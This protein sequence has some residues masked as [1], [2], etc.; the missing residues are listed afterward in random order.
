MAAK[1]SIIAR[2]LSEYDAKGTKQA[3]K[4]LAELQKNFHDFGKKAAE[5][6]AVAA[7]AVVGLSIKLGI[8]GVKAAMAENQQM[9]VLANTLKNTTGAN[10]AAIA[11][12]SR[13]IQQSA[14]RYNFQ[15]NELIPSL[16][17]LAVA[18]G[19]IT[20]AE[21]LQGL[22]MNI[23]ANKG[24]DLASVS[25]VLAKAYLGNFTAL[26]KMGVPLSDAAIKSKNFAVVVK[27]LDK[28]FGG[29]AAAAADTFAG[30]VGRIGIAFDMVKKTIGQAIIV[31]LQPF[32]DKFMNALPQIEKWLNKNAAAIASFFVTGI[33]YGV[34]FAQVLY[35]TFKFVADNI[36]IFSELG[37]VLAAIWMGTKI[38]AGVNAIIAAVKTVVAVY[39][40]LRAAA[41][42]AAFAEAIA[43]GGVAAAVGLAAATAAFIGINLALNKF[44]K[45][46][47]KAGKGVGDL[48]FNFKGLGTTAADYLKGLKLTNTATDTSN[49]LTAL[50]IASLKALKALG[51]TPTTSTDPIELEAARLN[52]V[53]QGNIAEAEKI[54]LTLA[55]LDAQMQ[56][57]IAIQRYSDILG[58]LADQHISNEEI[59]VL[60]KKWKMSQDEVVAYIAKVTGAASFDPTEL[61]SPGAVAALGWKNALDALNKYFLALRNQ[62]AV[63]GGGGVVSASP[64]TD[65]AGTTYTGGTL[66]SSGAIAG[67][68]D[69]QG[70]PVFI[71]APGAP[72]ISGLGT[73]GSTPFPAASGTSGGAAPVVNVTVMGSVVTQADLVAGVANGLMQSQLSGTNYTVNML[74]L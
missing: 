14:L 35:D 50:Q 26:R 67:A 63:G 62:P 52:L 59:A 43:T 58:V 8:D 1:G 41:L 65:A 55:A 17:S 57:N 44:E 31:A 4:D 51:V 73:F 30:R 12:V 37:A 9:T 74:N 16:Q 71:P 27:E 21:Q 48:K 13:Y 7:A 5:A 19:S 69:L 39:K 54:G 66:L 42:G 11:S 53:K 28:A 24:K 60:A 29:S 25:L 64:Q 6:T 38:A 32:L 23:S 3:R 46:A 61:G 36:V 47:A 18:T 56:D 70:N 15:E 49:K 22:A 34:A 45:D 33:S 72:T 2:I 10:E 68:T 20:K 40:A